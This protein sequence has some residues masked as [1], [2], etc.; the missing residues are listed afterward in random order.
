MHFTHNTI[1]YLIKSQRNNI[2]ANLHFILLE[3]ST[4]FRLEILLIFSTTISSLVTSNFN[5]L[6]SNEDECCSV[7]KQE[8]QGRGQNDM[9]IKQ[10]HYTDR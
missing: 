4:R 3:I 9:M 8:G 1:I 5:E 6:L 7:W 2:V 10:T